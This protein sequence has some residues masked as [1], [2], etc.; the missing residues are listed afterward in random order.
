MFIVLRLFNET[1]VAV[2]HIAAHFRMNSAQFTGRD[3][4]RNRLGI[5]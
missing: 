5:F 1:F 3:M 4:E 2:D